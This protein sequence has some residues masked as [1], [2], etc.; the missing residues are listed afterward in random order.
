MT[1]VLEDRSRHPSAIDFAREGMEPAPPISRAPLA[2]RIIGPDRHASR[3][4]GVT[5]FIFFFLVYVV[6]GLWMNLV[7]N[8][9]W[10]D[11]ASRVADASY[12]VFSRYPHLGAIGFVWNP[13]PSLLDIPLILARGVWAPLMTRGVAAI[14]VTAAFGAGAVVEVRGILVERGLPRLPR[15]VLVALFA[16]HPM[17]MLYSA[18]GMTE[19]DQVFM[20]LLVIRALMR[21]I[22]DDATSSLMWA[23]V[24][25]S[26]AYLVRYESAAIAGSVTVFVM[27]VTYWRAKGEPA[28]RR[29]TDAITDGLVVAIPFAVAFIAWAG[30]SW[31]LTGTAF[32]QFTSVYGNGNQ[33][34]AV[35]GA[36]GY[37]GINAALGSPWILP[38]RDVLAMEILL[39]AIIV[40]ALWLGLRRRDLT[41][42]LLLVTCGSALSFFMVTYAEKLTFPWFRFYILAVPLAV[43]L[44]G[45]FWPDVRSTK[46]V[47]PTAL[48]GWGALLLPILLLVP[49]LPVAF[50]AMLNPSI[51]LQEN[52]LIS[53]LEPN[54]HPA[55]NYPDLQPPD[56]QFQMAKYIESLHLPEGSVLMDTFTGWQIYLASQHNKVYVITSDYDFIR[57][58]NAPA[59]FNIKYILVP[60]PP[61][62]WPT[63]AVT[64][65]YPTMW[66]TGAGIAAQVL[67]SPVVGT[68]PAWKLYRVS[69]VNS[70][71][72]RI[73]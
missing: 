69:P 64:Q 8:W 62:S 35:A 23:G 22:W 42:V 18:N 40:V 50:F 2:Q 68:Q 25:L 9:I 3:A 26:L 10:G 71:I 47:M 52:P 51:G 44:V 5:I 36:G 24:G 59:E 58:L 33:V 7:G 28:R 16:L 34:S 13:L 63:N 70:S 67:Y 66:A 14:F 12:V 21:W 61:K 27:C 29:R 49:S 73:P 20:V 37:G 55:T 1:L 56:A 11:A 72:P 19:M 31:L 41:P 30:A 45:S 46:T 43:L 65:R 60:G 6:L 15:Y 39:P 38:P 53:L 4:G 32:A 57:D 54:S 48:Q 17:V